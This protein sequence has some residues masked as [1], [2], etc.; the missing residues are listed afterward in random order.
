MKQI[1]EILEESAV[2]LAKGLREGCWSSVEV[3]SAHIEKIRSVN[4]LLNAMVA[5]CFD[6]A[7]DAAEK[8]DARLKEWR[9]NNTGTALPPFLGVPCTIKEAFAVRDMPN[10]SGVVA[11]RQIIASADAD[12]VRLLKEAGFIVMGVTNVSELCIWMESTNPVYGRTSNPYDVSRTAGGSSGGEG[13]IV[14]AGASPVG[15]G[16]DVGGS[17]R[18]PAYFNGVFGHKCSSFLISNKGQ[19]PNAYDKGAAFLSS[20]PLCRKAED[21]APLV[22]VLSEGKLLEQPSPVNVEEMTVYTLSRSSLPWTSSKLLQDQQ[23]AVDALV[24]QG[25]TH[26]EITDK[27]FRKSVEIWSCMMHEGNEERFGDLLLDGSPFELLFKFA[28]WS[29]GKGQHTFPTLITLLGEKIVPHVPWEDVEANVALGVSMREDLISILGSTG[30]LFHPPHAFHVRKHDA[31]IFPPF[32]WGNTAIFN[33]LGLPVTQVPLGLTAKGLPKGVQVV[34]AFGRD[35]LT[36]Q[37][38]EILERALGGWVRPT[39]PGTVS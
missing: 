9:A 36:I 27:R 4:P 34:G 37:V 3:V 25:A 5:D 14:G 31:P 35:R 21:L 20:G 22:E 13:A 15:L 1:Q 29:I 10:T 33:V 30:V 38:A 23:Q 11:R 32:Q 19:F 39:G 7:L 8:A 16:S 17:I 28:R 2:S 18:M 6:S 24:A 26:R 12:A